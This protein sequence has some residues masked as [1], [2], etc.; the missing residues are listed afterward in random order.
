MEANIRPGASV[1]CF[2]YDYP[3][4]A[5]YQRCAVLLIIDDL[6]RIHKVAHHFDGT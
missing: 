3:Y 6:A 5:R 4:V 1:T 2:P